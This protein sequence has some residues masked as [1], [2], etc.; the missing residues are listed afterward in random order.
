M[1]PPA[2]SYTWAP[3]LRCCQSFIVSAMA[4]LVSSSVELIISFRNKTRSRSW[5]IQSHGSAQSKRITIKESETV[6]GVNSGLTN[7]AKGD[8]GSE[9]RY[10]DKRARIS[11]PIS[12]YQEKSNQYDSFTFMVSIKDILICV[13]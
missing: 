1:L 12:C 8:L 2:L 5:R 11:R 6:R 10:K 13:S 9:R 4:S 7:G 3:L